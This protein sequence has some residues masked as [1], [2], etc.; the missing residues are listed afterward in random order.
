[1]KCEAWLPIHTYIFHALTGFQIVLSTFLVIALGESS[2]PS[3]RLAILIGVRVISSC[4][5]VPQC[6]SSIPHLKLSLRTHSAT[7]LSPVHH[8]QLF[9]RV[10]WHVQNVISSSNDWLHVRWKSQH[11]DRWGTIRCGQEIVLH[12][13]NTHITVAHWIPLPTLIR[14]GYASAGLSLGGLPVSSGAPFLLR[15]DHLRTSRRSE[16][17]HQETCCRPSH[18][19]HSALKRAWGCST[20]GLPPKEGGALV[21][22]VHHAHAPLW[23]GVVRGK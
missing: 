4:G 2:P 7:N 22:L 5:S 6:W 18:I 9:T 19:S 17:A 23:H 8:C 1:M 20:L 12:S 16:Q 10:Y 14:L 15:I 11:W 3:L 21:G 13:P